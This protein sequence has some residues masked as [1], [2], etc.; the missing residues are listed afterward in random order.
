MIAVGKVGKSQ[1]YLRIV[2]AYFQRAGREAKDR[3]VEGEVG[4][5]S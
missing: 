1:K 3:P 2:D 4:N 5:L